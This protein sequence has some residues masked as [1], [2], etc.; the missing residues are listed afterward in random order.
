MSDRPGYGR[1]DPVADP[2][3]S[4]VAS[5]LA[6]VVKDIPSDQVALI[7]WSGGGMFAL[8]AAAVLGSRV[9]ACH[10]MHPYG[11]RGNPLGAGRLSSSHGRGPVRS[12]TSIRS[13][14]R[15]MQ[16]LR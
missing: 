6:A 12:G 9:R 2:T 15:G 13:D 7:G 11:G 10:S 4:A 16:F 14:Q 8:E 3:R 5:D 1:S